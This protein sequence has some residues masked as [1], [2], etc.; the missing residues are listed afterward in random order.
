[1]IQDLDLFILKVLISD[2]KHA[3]DFVNSNDSK[4]FSP[5]YWNFAT[6][7]VNYIKSYK[8]LPTLR[9]LEE[10]LTKSNN[11][12][13]IEQVRKIWHSL[14][15]IDVDENDYKFELE[16]IKKRF[17]ERQ[18]SAIKDTLSKQEP[19]IMDISKSIIDMQKTVQ[20]IKEL[21]EVKNFERKT[22]RN[23]IPSFSEKFNAKR[24]NPKLDPGLMTQYSAIDN[25]TNGLRP[26]DFMIIAGET[27]FGKSLLLLNLA[28]QSWLQK[29]T[30]YSTDFAEG[31][32]VVYFSLEMPYEDCF[33]RLVSRLSGVP[34]HK[35]EK[36]HT[37]DKEEFNKIKDVLAFI[38]SYPF[39]FEIIDVSNACATDLDIVL[40]DIQYNIDGVFVD[41]LGIM[42]PNDKNNDD[43]DWLKQG[44]ISQEIRAIARK[45]NLPIFSAVQLNRKNKGK[46]SSENIGLDRLARSGTI[47]THATHVIQI[48]TRQN[49]ESYPDFLY[50]IVKNRKGPKTH[51]KLLKNLACASLLEETRDEDTTTYF[52]SYDLDDISDKADLLDI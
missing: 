10:K 48:E 17:A 20:S 26:A 49:E 40:E 13:F 42:S 27:G 11:L 4:L 6:L 14:S 8:S 33:N 29:N 21:N 35:I 28:I 22:L 19:G 18:L 51:G 23:A 31:K 46:D 50:H 25:A 1:L 16:K 52:G 44:I 30:I 5:E 2:K 47:A 12:K 24:A 36:P 3:I 41:Y 39:E 15:N 43:Q 9:V 37:I 32:N 45:R 34:S 38:K 7:I